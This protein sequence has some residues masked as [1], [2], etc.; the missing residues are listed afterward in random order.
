M[1]RLRG[2]EEKKTAKKPKQKTKNPTAFTSSSPQVTSRLP[3]KR[4]IQIRSGPRVHEC[5]KGKIQS[6]TTREL[7]SAGDEARYPGEM[8]KTPSAT[9]GGEAQR[10]GGRRGQRRA[11]RRAAP[12]GEHLL[13]HTPPPPQK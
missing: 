13:N 8:R 2:G 3:H 10:H 4:R 7:G 9:S 5:E 12:P 6:G 1:A 11:G